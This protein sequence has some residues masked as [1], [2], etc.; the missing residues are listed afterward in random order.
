M[1]GVSVLSKQTKVIQCQISHR[2][3]LMSTYLKTAASKNPDL[4]NASEHKRPTEIELPATAKVVICGGGAQG[5]AIAYK[6]AEAGWG[7]NVLLL[8]QGDLG[9]GTTW[10]ATGLMGILKPN[11]LETKI[12]TLSRD[13]YKKLEEKNWYTGFKQCG[14]LWVAKKQDRMYQYKRMMASAVQHNIECKLLQ[15]PDEVSQYCGLVNKDD[16]LGGLW[17]PGDGV[18][19]P[20]EICLA[21]ACEA[22]DMGV[23]VM[24]QCSV[25]GV[26]TENGKVKSV[27]CKMGNGEV[28]SVECEYFVNSAGFW[29]RHVGEMS[30][31]SV[32]VPIHPCEHYHLHTRPVAMLP[33]DTPVVRDPDGHVYFR[34]NEGRFLAGGFEPK[35]KPAYMAEDLPNQR[36][37]LDADW[38]HFNILLQNL[39]H[40]VPAMKDAKL[41]RLTNGAEA[42]S[43]DGQWILGRAPEVENYFVAAGM[44]SNGIASAGGVGTVIAHW[45]TQE[46]PPFDMYNLDIARCLG[47]HNN[48]R[49]L[50]DRVSE[51]PGLNFA[52]TYPHSEFGTGRA[53][54]TSPIFP[55]LQAAGAQFGQVMG[56]ERPMYFKLKKPQS[57]D[58]GFI[59]Q[60]A[61][62]TAAA[63]QETLKMPIAKTETFYRPPWFQAAAE[64]FQAAREGVALCD[65]SSFSKTDL[66]SAGTEVVDFLQKVCSNNVD[67]PVGHI[68]HTGMQNKW[69]GYENDC[70]VFRLEKNRYMLMSPSIQQMRSLSW[71][72]RH[73]PKTV[74]L[75]DVTSLYT[76]LC[77]M[78]PHSRA[79]MQNLTSDKLDSINFK[80]GTCRVMDIACAPEILTM[81]MTHTGELG[82]VMYIPN[83]FA[84]HVYDA[85]VEEGKK[86]DLKHCGYYA[87]RAVR[88]EKFMAFWGQDLDSFATPMESG[89]ESRVKMKSDIDFIGKEALQKQVDEGVKKLFVMLLLEQM[90]HNSDLDPWPWGGES[91]YRNGEFCG[92][93]T[94]TSYG[95]SLN[96]QVCLGF[97]KNL[98]AD[99]QPQVIDKEYVTSGEFEVDILGIK[100]PATA[101]LYQPKLPKKVN[102]PEIVDNPQS[103]SM[104][105]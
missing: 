22:M 43:P 86:L 49:F 35:A 7:Q 5:A 58:M 80:Q 84:I 31:P 1:V 41:E 95:F 24:E 85:I 12:A 76:T 3:R 53:L 28:K 63:S 51:V 88:I 94:T 68:V 21:L 29:S 45:I 101:R 33:L 74:V 81:S 96:K 66:W 64:E 55:K 73:L 20:H 77:V 25:R 4:R 100:Y 18:A 47:Y 79:L 19:N 10:H 83:E 62:E 36:T 103:M 23:K 16:L 38:D 52:I 39:L 67:I 32:A 92:T 75:Q 34:E 61:L 27:E 17:V 11:H 69:G 99:G 6:L 30:T 26:K 54:R 89:R 102:L 60:E 71:L 46:R 13:L 59:G 37:E 14:S 8:E 15:G 40:R 78:G 98:D 65:Y 72:R 9:G 56:Y 104:F 93:V 44:R 97:I 82:Y 42:F 91:I 50:R 105:S 70:T 87:Q 48:K 57:L 2:K 90:D